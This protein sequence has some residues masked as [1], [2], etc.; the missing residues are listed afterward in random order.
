M[1]AKLELLTRDELAERFGVD[2]RTITNWVAAGMPQRSRSG[3]PVYAWRECYAWREQQ[4]R[5]DARATRHAGGSEDKRL[6]MVELKLREQRAIT[7]QAE[8]DVDERRGRTVTIDFMKTEFRRAGES[9][10]AGLLSIPAAW[11]GRLAPCT[12]SVERQ[13]AL[14]EAVNELLPLLGALVDYDGEGAPPVIGVVVDEDGTVAAEAPAEAPA[15][16]TAAEVA[17]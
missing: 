11:D 12:T 3:R 6:E 7:E 4:I 10:R 13:L 5:D 8:A 16:E 17:S 15:A 1:P 14:Q 2:V 9:I